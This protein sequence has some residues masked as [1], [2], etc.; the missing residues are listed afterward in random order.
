VRLL[1]A[2]IIVLTAIV[3]VAFAAMNPDKVPVHYYF[4]V[5]QAPL[6]LWLAVALA[7][8]VGVGALVCVGTLLRLRRENARLKRDLRLASEEVR[9]L[10]SLP[11]NDP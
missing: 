11:L 9:N 3:G 4:G 8:G 5:G 2:L 10:R 1:K 6:A 7:L